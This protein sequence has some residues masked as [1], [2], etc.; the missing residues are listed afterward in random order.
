[1]LSLEEGAI[2]LEEA[3]QNIVLA[4]R[5]NEENANNEDNDI[6]IQY[7]LILPDSVNINSN[8]GSGPFLFEPEKLTNNSAS[9]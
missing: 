9:C 4:L 7:K 6:L 5:E 2:T 8:I 1:M 3:S